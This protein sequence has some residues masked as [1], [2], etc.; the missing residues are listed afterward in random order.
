MSKTQQSPLPVSDVFL[1]NP[2]SLEWETRRLGDVA[3]FFLGTGLSKVDLSSDGKR[4]CIHYGELFTTYKER[5]AEVLHGTN[6]NDDFFYSV[7]NDVLMPTSDVTPNGLATASCI[8]LPDVILGGGI[9]V[10]RASKSILNGEFLA[11]TI[12]HSPESDN[13]A[14]V[15]HYGLSSVRPRLGVL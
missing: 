5:I 15:G 6:R 9:L 8:L 10:I 7:I 13:A 1:G 3:S 11:Y 14:R 12:R 4:R 2:S